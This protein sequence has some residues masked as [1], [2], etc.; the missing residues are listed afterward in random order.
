MG[1]RAWFHFCRII[2]YLSRTKFSHN[3]NFNAEC[4]Q[5]VVGALNGGSIEQ[6]YFCCCHI[7]DITALESANLPQLKY[8]DFSGNNV[9]QTLS[10][11]NDYSNLKVLDLSA[12]CTGKKSYSVNWTVFPEINGTFYSIWN[13]IMAVPCQILHL[14]FYYLKLLSLLGNHHLTEAYLQMVASAPDYYHL[15]TLVILQDRTHE[16]M[17]GKCIRTCSWIR[18]YELLGYN[19][20]VCV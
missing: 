1:L 2:V 20:C 17:R 12:N 3:A 19:K 14:F 13:I 7:D 10:S 18:W 8:L 9:I 4:F 11:L 16:L 5:L 6:L 15:M